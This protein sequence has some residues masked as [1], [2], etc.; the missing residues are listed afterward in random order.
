QGQAVSLL[1]GQQTLFDALSVKLRQ[2]MMFAKSKE[3]ALNAA[4]QQDPPDLSG[5]PIVLTDAVAELLIE[6]KDST[7]TPPSLYT[8]MQNALRKYKKNVAFA[9]SDELKRQ[10]GRIKG[11]KELQDNDLDNPSLGI[12]MICSFSIPIITLV[13]F[14][15]L[16]IFVQLLNIVF[17]WL[18]FFKI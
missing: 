16:M 13:A 12:G 8:L 10:M 15:L 14:I 11:L 3:D 1:P 2:S 5:M 17:W 4:S 18:P 9:I 6:P 7:S